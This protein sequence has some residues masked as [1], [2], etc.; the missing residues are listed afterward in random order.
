[1]CLPAG[2]E[3]RATDDVLYVRHAGQLP[4][5]KDAGKVKPYHI[6]MLKRNNVWM[7]LECARMG[8]DILL[9]PA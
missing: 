1:M 9:S 4:A 5:L 2:I 8:R 6:S 3:R 7:A